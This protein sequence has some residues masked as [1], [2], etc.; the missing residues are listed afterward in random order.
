MLSEFVFLGIFS[1]SGV[2]CEYGVFGV[3]VVGG[4]VGINVLFFFIC[5]LG[6]MGM[7]RLLWV[8]EVDLC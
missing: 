5:V 8:S 6:L 7:R 1:C 3:L 2:F 4:E